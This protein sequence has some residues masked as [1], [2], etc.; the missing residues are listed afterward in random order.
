LMWRLTP[1][2]ARTTPR[3][4]RNC[5]ARFLTSRSGT[6]GNGSAMDSL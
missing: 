2:T 6:S 5:V 4:V 1:S 3:S